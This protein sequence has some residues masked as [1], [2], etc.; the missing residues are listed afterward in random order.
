MPVGQFEV[1]YALHDFKAE[2][3]DEVSFSAGEEIVVLERDDEFGD[4]WWMGRTQDGQIG[5]FPA[6]FTSPTPVSPTTT[7]TSTVSR[8]SGDAP[9]A[10]PASKHA[11]RE[12]VDSTGTL[13]HYESLMHD[14]RK[15]ISLSADKLAAARPPPAVV[16][17]LPSTTSAPAERAPS[18]LPAPNTSASS[19]SAVTPMRPAVLDWSV[20][21]VAAWV[22]RAGFSAYADM[23]AA[24]EINGSAL[25]QLSL[26]TLKDVGITALGKRIQL[27]NAIMDLKADFG[28]DDAGEPSRGRSPVVRSLSRG[29]SASAS[30]SRGL[31]LDVTSR[32]A[33]PSGGRSP[34]AARSNRSSQLSP[35][36]SPL[37]SAVEGS[38]VGSS[39]L[40]A[41]VAVLPPGAARAA[42]GMPSVLVSPAALKPAE[43]E[44]SLKTLEITTGFGSRDGTWRKRFIVLKGGVLYWF[45]DKQSPG[46]ALHAIYIH[47]GFKIAKDETIKPGKHGI[48]VTEVNPAAGPRKDYYFYTDDEKAARMWMRALTKA[49]IFHSQHE[50]SK[51]GHTGVEI[52]GDPSDVIAS[53][54]L[55]DDQIPAQLSAIQREWMAHDPTRSAATLTRSHSSTRRPPSYHG[56]ATSLES[57]AG[58]AVPAKDPLVRSRSTDPYVGKAVSVRSASPVGRH[59]WDDGR[60]REIAAMRA[61]GAAPKLDLNLSLSP[62]AS[63]GPAAT[64]LVA[65][66]NEHLPP[67]EHVV[68]LRD[69]VSGL[70]MIHF[71]TNLTKTPLPPH[72]ARAVRDPAVYRIDWID[73]WEVA[74]Q[75]ASELFVIVSPLVTSD[76]LAA[77]RVEAIADFLELV[78]ATFGNGVV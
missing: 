23:F 30:A 27:M 3:E 14:L 66:V 70:A 34:S 33:S 51:R 78:Q 76:K 69:L 22:T 24:N 4:G 64:D 37:A 5:L 19:V 21:D 53:I 18:P 38:A 47:S 17:L 28:L 59:A 44:S 41:A 48:R 49:T 55:P 16:P 52:I 73:N 54:R 77:G 15:S 13:D 29:A 6:N 67:N 62:A 58:P 40:A 25:I 7:E 26:S 42:Q 61:A 39:V 56:T 31:H 75:W 35:I 65:Y 36:G 57:D 8:E 10:A 9:P 50:E 68:G 72:F 2:D 11:N 32:V 43:A 71:L 60:E 20:A 46:P 45:K 63:A 74:L 1:V 12:S